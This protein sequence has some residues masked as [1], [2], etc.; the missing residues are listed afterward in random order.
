MSMVGCFLLVPEMEV[1]SVLSEPSS[2]S[3]IV[4]AAYQEHGDDLVDVGKAWHCLHY[5]LTGTAWEGEPPLNFIAI[6]GIEVGDVDVGYG[7]A[8]A[9]RNRELRIIS[10]A[11]EQISADDLRRRFDGHRMDAL[12][13]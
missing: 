7:P 3:D 12:E 2:V 6:G 11:L 1:Q 8:R 10:E 4:E 13:I 5:L 9:F